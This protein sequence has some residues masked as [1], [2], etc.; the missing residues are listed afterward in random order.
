MLEHDVRGRGFNFFEL[1][2]YL[3]WRFWP[4]RD[5]LPF[6][7]IHQAGTP[8]D[9]TLLAFASAD[10]SAWQR[11]DDERRFD[12][13]V[14]ST[15]TKE[16]D[17]LL[18]VLDRDTTRWALVNWDDAAALYLRRDGRMAALA[19]RERFRVMPG[20]TGRLGPLSAQATADSTVRSALRRELE[21]AI[22]S[23][24]WNG[25]ASN[26]L[27]MIDL[28]E[29]RYHDSRSHLMAAR[30]A[31]DDIPF[32]DERM[33]QAWLL[34][35]RAREAEACF[36]RARRGGTRSPNVDLLLARAL[37]AQGRRAEAIEAYRL[38]MGH[39]E[40]QAAARDSLA[41]LGERR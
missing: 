7:D 36:R 11:L 22:A 5:R 1:G 2:G 29:G 27:A 37:Q 3:N 28:F 23:S 13:V 26:R 33:G 12:Y 41:A 9:R 25:S 32:F 19:E 31:R 17:R 6:M 14:I 38:A 35:G 24:R 20:G 21:R 39:P 8:L 10:S 40:T 34:D 30:A 16:G 4:V 18:E 15:R